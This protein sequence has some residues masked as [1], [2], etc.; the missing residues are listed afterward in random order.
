MLRTTRLLMF[1]RREFLAKFFFLL[2]FGSLL[3]LIDAFVLVL[4]TTVENM[5]L[6]FALLA[7]T[8]FVG[9]VFVLN[10]ADGCLEDIRHQV[11]QG[12]YPAQRFN[13]LAGLVLSGMLLVMPGF[14]TDAIGILLYLPVIRPLV[15]SVVTARSESQ[16][17]E[18]YEYL[19]MQ[20]DDLPDQPVADETEQQQQ[21]EWGPEQTPGSD[22][23]G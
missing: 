18:I 14:F 22:Q 8:G 13:E 2:L 10:S 4:I 15:G 20:D 6:V 21:I 7:G 1:V 16:L 5:Y 17:H 12:S 19:K 9:V 23:R 11:L 3:L